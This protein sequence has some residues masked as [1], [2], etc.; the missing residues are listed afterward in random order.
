MDSIS[1]SSPCEVYRIPPQNFS[2]QLSVAG[3]YMHHK[4]RYL[5]LHRSAGKP[6]EH[7]WG[8]PAGKL[9]KGESPGQGLL[10]EV[11][12][13]TGVNLNQSQVQEVGTLYLRH[14]HMDFLYHMF[15]QE[16]EEQAEVTLSKEHQ[17]FRWVNPLEL[18][19]LPLMGGAA[20]AFYHFL[21]LNTEK[22]LPR[23][24]FYFVRH[25]E[26]DVNRSPNIKRVDYDL[27]LN[28][29]GTQQAI[30]GRAVIAPLP[31][32]SVWCS[33]I[34]RAQQTRDLILKGKP[35]KQHTDERI[36]ECKAQVWTKM[37]ELEK[38]SGYEVDSSIET[39]L[40]RVISGVTASLEE[41]SPPLIVAHGGVYWA[42]CYHLGIKTLPWKIGNCE[43]VHF[44]PK[45]E[46]EWQA[47]ILQERA[48]AR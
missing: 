23:K 22:K 1:P 37:I 33:P 45:G 28:A 21:A 19:Q 24:S 26:T 9:E 39:F 48:P 11:Q 34:Q 35:L 29:Q 13:E 36:R 2:P 41:D 30:D 8:V 44:Q 17:A 47:E 3:C 4:G 38:G 25:G 46:Q 6:Q 18:F 42:L 10:R 15:T 7:T 12:E 32:Q 31:I 27:P 5:F 14:G 20:E 16:M 40:H 43:V